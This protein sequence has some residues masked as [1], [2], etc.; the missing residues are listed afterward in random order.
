MIFR[1]L[2]RESCAM[3]GDKASQGLL[4]FRIFKKLRRRLMA[5]EDILFFRLRLP[6]ELADM[7][8]DMA[9]D[10]RRPINAQVVLLLEK[11]LGIEGRYAVTSPRARLG[12]SIAGKKRDQ[13]GEVDLPKQ[14]QA[15][16]AVTGISA[17][18]LAVLKD[19]AAKLL[20]L[21]AGAAP[22]RKTAPAKPARSSK[23]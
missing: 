10:A 15:P 23:K 20:N 12:A 13:P 7:I 1:F 22:K 17:D 3:A 8:A 5:D 11:A 14:T 4:V 18:E 9:H 19:L 2:A 6:R 16:S 21:D